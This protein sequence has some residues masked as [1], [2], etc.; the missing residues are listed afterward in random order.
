MV[1]IVHCCDCG[2]EIT[3]NDYDEETD[4]YICKSCLGPIHNPDQLELLEIPS[5]LRK[6]DTK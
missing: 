2:K 1:S 6:A 3:T 5:F 4:E